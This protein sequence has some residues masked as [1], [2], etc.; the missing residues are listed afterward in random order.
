MATC[1]N[2]GASSRDASQTFTVEQVMVP[3][4]EIPPIKGRR[5]GGPT[6]IVEEKHRLTH[7]ECGWHIDGRVEGDYFLAD[8]DGS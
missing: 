2:C 5:V 4:Q 1:P 6:F 8:R 3:V 7:E